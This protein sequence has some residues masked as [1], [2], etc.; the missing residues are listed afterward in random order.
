MY[1][2]ILKRQENEGCENGKHLEITAELHLESPLIDG[3]TNLISETTAVRVLNKGDKEVG[4]EWHSIR[5]GRESLV[6]LVRF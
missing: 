4:F 5:H 6:K 1:L 2:V 3:F